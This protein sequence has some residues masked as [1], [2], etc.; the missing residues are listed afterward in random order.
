MNFMKKRALL[1]LFLCSLATL[2]IFPEQR[3]S[4][5]STGW[6]FENPASIFIGAVI[7]V[8]LVISLLRYWYKKSTPQIPTSAVTTKKDILLTCGE[9]TQIKITQGNII[10]SGADAIVNAANKE[11]SCGGGVCGAIFDAAGK[12]ALERACKNVTLK[13]NIR[14]PVGTSVRTESFGLQRSKNILHIIHTVGPDCRIAE[15]KRSWHEHLTNA[16]TS[17][18]ALADD[19][20][21]TSIA[22][23]LISAG[24]YGCETEQ[25]FKTALKAM[26]DYCKKNSNTTITTIQ[27]VIFDP[28]TFGNARTWAQ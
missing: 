25:A 24:I 17:A 15:E 19:H 22:F 21:V 16:Y 3:A 2:H 12:K 13:G 1:L 4:H 9:K 11:L 6:V 5:S 10:N 14:C 26:K 23:P 7:I 27:L 28:S 18:L 8:P 20:K